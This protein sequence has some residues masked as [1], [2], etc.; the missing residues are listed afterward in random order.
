MRVS[1]IVTEY[2]YNFG[3][4]KIIKFHRKNNNAQ[5]KIIWKIV[6]KKINSF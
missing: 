2:E 1:T 6:L 5:R 4:R 3:I